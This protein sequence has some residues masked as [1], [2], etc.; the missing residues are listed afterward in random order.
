MQA[1]VVTYYNIKW[2]TTSWTYSGLIIE[3]EVFNTYIMC[4]NIWNPGP[5]SPGYG[6]GPGALPRLRTGEGLQAAQSA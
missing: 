5:D 6:G 2:V 3:I 1:H 4:R